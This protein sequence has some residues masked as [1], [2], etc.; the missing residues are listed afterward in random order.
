MKNNRACLKKQTKQYSFYLCINLF[1]YTYVGKSSGS[2][3]RPQKGLYLFSLKFHDFKMY[4][5]KKK[6]Q[7][8][9]FYTGMKIQYEFNNAL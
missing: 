2:W 4:W 3:F 1:Y 9:N 6:G 7:L 5:N 8:I